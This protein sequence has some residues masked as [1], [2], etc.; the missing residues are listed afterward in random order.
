MGKIKTLASY[1][2]TNF[3]TPRTSE[4]QQVGQNIRTNK[5]IQVYV[6]KEAARQASA[7]I[8][9]RFESQAL[10]N[11]PFLWSREEEFK[12]SRSSV[13]DYLKLYEVQHWIYACTDAIARNSAKVPFRIFNLNTTDEE[14]DR[15]GDEVTSG[16]TWDLF[17]QPNPIMTHYNFF[18]GSSAYLV[19][20]GNFF[21]E[22]ND[23]DN[24][25]QLYLLRPDYIEAKP[26][27][28]TLKAGY[29]YDPDGM[30]KFFEPEDIFHVKTFH[31]R[32]ELYGLA[33]ANPAE[34]STIVDLYV[35]TYVQNFFKKG[36]APR[37]YVSIPE[38]VGEETFQRLKQEINTDH[39]GVNNMHSTK[40]LTDGAKILNIGTDPDK[41]LLPDHKKWNRDEILAV[42]NVPPIMLGS[43]DG[44]H[45][46]NG[47][48]QQ[49]IF[50]EQTIMPINQLI[51]DAI[52]K[53]FLW[54]LD[55][56]G[57]FDY[58]NIA[59]L[60]EDIKKKAETGKVL[61]ESGQWTQN[62]VRTDLWK[63]DEKEGGDEL[64]KPKQ[65]MQFNVNGGTELPVEGE[66]DVKRHHDKP[67]P[68][69]KKIEKELR[70]DT[71]TQAEV[72]AEFEAW[73]NTKARPVFLAAKSGFDKMSA[74][75]ISILKK[76]KARSVFVGGDMID[77]ALGALDK[78]MMDDILK[79]EKTAGRS[80]AAQNIRRLDPDVTQ[81]T[82]AAMN[83]AIDT[84]LEALAPKATKNVLKTQKDRV[85]GQLKDI[86]AKKKST[87]DAA[88][89]LTEYFKG[90]PRESYPWA[91][92][93]VRTE[94][95][96]TG[97]L[98]KFEAMVGSGA[99]FKRWIA[100]GPPD[101]RENHT[102][103]SG[104]I[105]PIGKAFSIGLMFPGDPSAGPDEVVN[106]RCDMIMSVGE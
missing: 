104:E 14:Q 70:K 54:P 15:H 47:D 63:R 69:D 48:I 37:N 61:I 24:P 33:K 80:F 45:Y 36:G 91:K 22:K 44:T 59:V 65:T 93:I 7:I 96:K 97:N 50:W 9:R 38:E 53:E 17:Y 99:K 81:E 95:L 86:L 64:Q 77:E 21:W 26:S 83:K 32:S 39:D 82:I 57:Q 100:T 40:V 58:S 75:T 51:E 85:I 89:Q 42:F 25:T 84:R 5:E 98:S 43:T 3:F 66:G 20:S 52:N 90:T 18:Y 13:H 79:A 41:T 87:A 4:I 73:E 31:P 76:H 71:R 103:I 27:R 35:M 6:K 92:V 2:I 78:E 72:R 105:Q 68:K 101:D 62:E 10:S 88:K 60:Q 34:R 19:L 74:S 30:R 8:Q 49:V 16:A 94:N 56:E 11:D 102:A 55:M 23:P 29:I 106:C 46:N 1:L 67:K 28:D 12:T